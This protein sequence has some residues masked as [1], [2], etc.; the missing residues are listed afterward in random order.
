M[1]D[2]LSYNTVSL[3]INK[4][5][6]CST[7]FSSCAI[8]ILFFVLVLPQWQVC[9][10][11]NGSHRQQACYRIFVFFFFDKNWQFWIVFYFISVNTICFAICSSFLK[12]FCS[13]TTGMVGHGIKLFQ[14]HVS[15]ALL[16][17]SISSTLLINIL[18]T[19]FYSALALVLPDKFQEMVSFWNI[20]IAMCQKTQQI[21]LTTEWMVVL[22][23]QRAHWQR[24]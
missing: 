22:S 14:S 2:M 18:N 9:Y 10:L 12:R 4:L 17:P 5:T 21:L 16:S 3:T 24:H 15:W 19:I 13:L 11:L 20:C 8:F 1:T 23:P 7:I 6:I